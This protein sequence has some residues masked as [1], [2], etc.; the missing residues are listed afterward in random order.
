VNLG[1]LC[2]LF[3][4]VSWGANLPLTAKLFTA[5]D[6]FFMTPLRIA[7]A[8]G[9][10]ALVWWFQREP[11]PVPL[12]LTPARH[13]LMS[14][15]MAAFFMLYNL[16][17]KFTHPITAAAII[18]GVPVYA[19]I[20]MRLAT[21]AKLERGFVGATV[22]TLLGAG[23]AIYGRA[24]A[25]GTGLRLEGGEP[26]LV[27]SLMCWTLYSIYAQRFFAPGVSQLRRTLT[28]TLGTLPWTIGAWLV[29][30]GAGFTGAPL[31]VV[32]TEAVV[33]L[34]VTAVFSTAL[35]GVAWNI[36]VNRVGLAVGSVWQNTVPVFGVLI[37]LLFGIQPTVEQLIGGVIVM[38]GV[39]YLQWQKA[40]P[41][42]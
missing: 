8:C 3:A 15:L 10:L 40:R 37:A 42:P 5:F 36:G 7:F 32:D 1:T 39:A 27:L 33:W 35:A 41:T 11:R 13:A 29:I 16:G 4:A 26:L 31:L 20:T 24:K 17:L 2:Y 23:V 38:A 28:A 14:G 18:A 6:P 22:L 21:G 12:G 30:W 34:L 19:G 9:V 25:S